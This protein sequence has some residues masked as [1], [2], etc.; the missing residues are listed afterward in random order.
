[1]FQ[2]FSRV[3]FKKKMEYEQLE[4][5]KISFVSGNNPNLAP[6]ANLWARSFPCRLKRFQTACAHQCS[7]VW[8]SVLARDE[9]EE[10][11]HE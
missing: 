3:A 11:W 6:A 4:A 5:G 8:L 1:M 7:C 9:S 10:A 2:F